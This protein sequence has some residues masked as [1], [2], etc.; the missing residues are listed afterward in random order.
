MTKLEK[1]FV[2]YQGHHGDAG[3]HVADVIFPAA[4]YTEQNGI[5]V[6][7]EGRVQ[8]AMRAY[9]PFGEARED[10]AIIRAL[11]GKMGKALPYDD[12]FAL[13]QVMIADAPVLGRIDHV[14]AGAALDLSKLGTKGAA[15]QRPICFLREQLL[16]NQPN[17]PGPVIRWQNVQQ[18]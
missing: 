10:W 4:A 14:A 9:F 8:M 13:R 2:V 7:M 5:Y 11:S 12:L 15:K 3:A 1:A 6:N 17:C 18:L 16:S